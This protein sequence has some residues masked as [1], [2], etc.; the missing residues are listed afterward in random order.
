MNIRTKAILS[1]MLIIA[2]LAVV[3]A[4]LSIQQQHA[5]LHSVI[6]GKRENAK[7][8]AANLQEQ[9]YAP[10]KG[11][12]VSLAT[13]K[14]EVIAA[15]AKRD[16]EALYKATL[17]FYKTIKNKN[18]Y[19]EIMHFHLPDNTSFLRMHLP[20]LHSDE[21]AEI[22]PIIREVN[23]S[24]KQLAG[25]EV[26]KLGLFY[27]IVQPVFHGGQ[28]VGALEFGLRYEKLL[29]LLR[30]RVC[31]EVAISIKTSEWRKA[32]LVDSL[33][34]SHG[35]YT[36]LPHGSSVFARLPHQP[37]APGE[38][39]F[40]DNGKEYVIF[41]DIEL[42]D[43]QHQQI[44]RVPIGLDITKEQAA[45]RAL[46]IK[47]VAVSLL[48]LALAFLILYFSFGQ[49]L[50]RIFL[51]NNSL[52]ASNQDLTTA[53]T[54][55]ENI[56]ATM[57]D[58][59]LVTSRDG[60]INKANHAICQLTEKQEADLIGATI[61][62]L[63]AEGDSL[64]A[65]LGDFSGLT[66]LRAKAEH[67][68]LRPDG[69]PLAV[70]V[71]AAPL[72]DP[73]GQPL[74]MVWIITDISERKKAETALRQAH[75][76]LEQRVEE[77]TRELAAANDTLT[78]EMQERKRVEAELR[79][80]QKLRAIGTLAG[81]IA[82]DF[83]NILSAI[84]GYTQLALAES[85][86]APTCNDYLKEV[87][88]AGLRAKDL[89]A[90]IL[91]FSRKGEQ[92][93]RSLEI[94]PIIKEA[95]KLLRASLPANIE[96][97]QDIAPQCGAV[98]ADPTQIHQVIMNLCT[99]AW[100]A[101]QQQGGTLRISLAEAPPSSLPGG[102]PSGDYLRLTV[103]DTGC[104][105]DAA[106]LERIF[107]PYFTTK[108]SGKGTG[109][110]LAVTHGIVR[111]HGGQI[112]VTSTV[113]KGSTFSVFL[114]LHKQL[115]P[116]SQPTQEHEVQGGHER[117]LVVDDEPE[118]AELLALF[119]EKHGYQVTALH[120]SIAAWEW[121]HAN[122]DG[123]DLVITDMAMPRLTGLDLSRRLLEKRPALPIILCTGYSEVINEAS[124]KQHGL[125]AF[126]L[127]PFEELDLVSL[128]R[129][130]LDGSSPD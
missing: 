16:R 106:T 97:S 72:S 57:S 120:D 83:N 95:L 96:I 126:F 121:F 33:K 77:R 128:V 108:E 43:Y 17:P 11:R 114:P 68:L 2:T 21:L 119:L 63:L 49:L 103:E 18:P 90:Q 118:I 53:K 129:R 127:K 107:E 125:S 24:H 91:T 10:Y 94:Q 89:V 4:F 45:A 66:A 112:S 7:Q 62:H 85:Q 69:D 123:V 40:S 55:V 115:L 20:G 76:L 67:R 80:A 41:T 74:G 51:L 27:R 109:L 60:I 48:L 75:D 61:Y 100:H 29:D 9:A 26:G 46:I 5:H 70:L 92:E 28:Y 58:G 30:E 65:E 42:K 104:G 101:M 59:L 111:G 73:L 44:A 32:T 98:L 110:G 19:F 113:G 6:A 56:L 25:Y 34:I 13:T 54:Y 50:Q 102:L 116:E 82:H 87:F 15:F 36:I 99:N 130:V 31:P 86:A 93:M 52:A 81:G 84:L 8:L 78:R 117:V 14:Q 38:V 79:Q 3:F 47:I 23:V 88:T 122:P 22:R 71:S 12:I 64:A 1:V 105:M 35:E 124:A 39:R 37:T